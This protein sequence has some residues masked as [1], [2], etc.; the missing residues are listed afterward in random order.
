MASTLSTRQLTQRLQQ[1]E[2]QELIEVILTMCG[3][4]RE[5]KQYCQMEFGDP[6]HQ[7]A[8]LEIAREKMRKHI[9]PARRSRSHRPRTTRLRKMISDFRKISVFPMH[10]ADLTLYWAELAAD[11][12]A[13]NGYV[14]DT[15]FAPTEKALQETLTL[16]TENALFPYFQPRLAA[17]HHN[18]QNASSKYR[19]FLTGMVSLLEK[20]LQGGETAAE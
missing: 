16:I 3:R 10:V 1:L 14:K 5:A 15:F 20:C 9:F 18:L 8:L 12:I 17:L 2:Q 11:Y 19:W 4:I 6:S 13:Q 7:N